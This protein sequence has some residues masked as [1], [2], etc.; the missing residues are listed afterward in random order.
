MKQTSRRVWVGLLLA[1]SFSVGGLSA[2]S[3]S[4]GHEGESKALGQIGLPL[5]TQGASG[6][7]Y[8]LR[9]ATFVVQ[10]QYYDYGYGEA[11]AGGTNSNPGTVVVSSET[12]PNASTISLSL[13]EGY[14]YVR[15]LPGWNMEKATPSGA[16]SVEATLLSGENQWVYI[17]RQNTSY[18]EYSFGIGGREI[19][20][21]GKL[22]IAI[23]V[24]E[25]AGAGGGSAG[26]PEG[27]Y[28]GLA[29]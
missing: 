26:A 16:Q 27:G 10:N 4:G 25:A 28:S 9:H 29:E 18:A 23:D 14:Y 2:C 22:N 24:Q 20:L 6:V 1:G 11:G 12:N 21:N 8:R 19:W 7:T 5:T 13:E 3:G 15:L 17:S